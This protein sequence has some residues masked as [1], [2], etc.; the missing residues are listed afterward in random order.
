MNQL[1][2]LAIRARQVTLGDLF[3]TR[4]RT[5]ATLFVVVGLALIV[6][7]VLSGCS[8]K[9]REP[10]RDAPVGARNEQPA[11]LFMM[12][13]GFSNLAAKCDGTARVYTLY[14]GDSA[15]GAGFASPNHPKCGGASS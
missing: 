13:D 4:L 7:M 10:F 2:L 6:G 14:H 9:A 12:P 3:Q 8:D 1:R 15:Y 5:L 11:D